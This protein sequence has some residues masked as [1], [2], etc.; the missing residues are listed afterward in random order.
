MNVFYL[1]PRKS[2]STLFV[3]ITNQKENFNLLNL[4]M[5]S[6][7]WSTS[8]LNYFLRYYSLKKIMKFDWSRELWAITQKQEFTKYEESGVTDR[9]PKIKRTFIWCLLYEILVTKFFKR[10]REITFL[11]PF[12]SN[13]GKHKFTGKNTLRQFL[14]INY[15]RPYRIK[16]TNV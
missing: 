12:C 9:E 13:V 7:M 15:S 2:N 5:S 10:T 1:P 6:H 3:L 16:K 4:Q 14:L 8:Y 11:V